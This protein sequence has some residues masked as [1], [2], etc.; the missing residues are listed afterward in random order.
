MLKKG[1]GLVK[2]E[3]DATLLAN[4]YDPDNDMKG[5]SNKLLQK[6]REKSKNVEK[7]LDNSAYE[8][9]TEKPKKTKKKQNTE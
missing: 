9:E 1:E 2:D 3:A 5:K 6:E 7:G 4:V 8:D